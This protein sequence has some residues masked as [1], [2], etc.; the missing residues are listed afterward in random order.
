MTKAWDQEWSFSIQ[1]VK[2]RTQSQVKC[3]IWN[4]L[5]G[6][7][8]DDKQL[9]HMFQAVWKPQRR[10]LQCHKDGAVTFLPL[11]V[12]R[13][14]VGPRQGCSWQFVVGHDGGIYDLWKFVVSRYPIQAG[15]TN[16]KSSV[17]RFDSIIRLRHL[18]PTHHILIVLKTMKQ[19]RSVREAG[20]LQAWISC[21]SCACM[22][23]PLN[24]V[25]E[26]TQ[27][28]TSRS[29]GATSPSKGWN[30]PITMSLGWFPL[31]FTGRIPQRKP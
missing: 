23:H 3:N 5:L 14:N 18:T 21:S 24:V 6:I 13:W 31:C 19:R 11:A 22:A 30:Q 9:T 1:E 20:S 12:P 26:L 27:N 4:K 17:A 15:G 2:P 28:R 25:L 29:L 10:L 16:Y 8:P 7:N